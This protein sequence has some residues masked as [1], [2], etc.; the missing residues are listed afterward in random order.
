MTFD[1]TIIEYTVTASTGF[2]NL[3]VGIGL[4][5]KIIQIKNKKSNG[6][7]ADLKNTYLSFYVKSNDSGISD[8]T[9]NINNQ[10]SISYTCISR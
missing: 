1:K 7:L 4:D 5:N 6:G 2:T 10:A 8:L 3:S 9:I